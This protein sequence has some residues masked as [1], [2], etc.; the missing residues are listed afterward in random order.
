MV[1]DLKNKKYSLDV[2]KQHIYA[3]NLL[4]LLKTQIIDEYF[5]VNFI[6]NN[7]Y[8]FCKNEQ[9][10]IQQLLKLQPHLNREKISMIQI[11]NSRF[12]FF[13]FETFNY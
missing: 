10:D 12:D 2:L 13:D 3:I 6:L 8:Q 4:E 1:L 9:I 7:D 5:A 11:N